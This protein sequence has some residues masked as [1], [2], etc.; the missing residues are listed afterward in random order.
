MGDMHLDKAGACS[1]LGAF[2]SIVKMKMKSNVI[3]AIPLVE[4]SVDGN[5]F[6]QGDIIKSYNG[7]TVEITNTD[8]EGRLILADTLSYIQ[9]NYKGIK[10]IIEISTLTGAISVAVGQN[11]TGIVGND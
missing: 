7:L 3:M 6:R 10:N 8:A 9:K 11:Y 4:N 2:M 5:S 1:T